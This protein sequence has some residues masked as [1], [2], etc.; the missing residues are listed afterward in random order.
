MG[1]GS[2]RTSAKTYAKASVLFQ[3]SLD[4][5]G[6]VVLRNVVVRLKPYLRDKY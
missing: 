3:T 4:D 6:V 2:A 1:G 5:C